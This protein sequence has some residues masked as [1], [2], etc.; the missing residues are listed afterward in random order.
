MTRAKKKYAPRAFESLG[1]KFIDSDGRKRTDTSANIFESML[2]S[3]AWKSLNSKQQVLYLVCKAQF[4]GKRKPGRDFPDVE[5]FQT[6]EAFYLNW[7]SVQK[8]G[9]Y[10]PTM[11]KNFYA[12]MRALIDR[13]FIILLSSGKSH[14]QKNIYRFGARW[15]EWDDS[16]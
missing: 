3:P 5:T 6:D 16:S 12:D 2:L 1:A 9:L 8:Y 13:G 15:R 7:G 4:Y 14:H 10:K 11:S